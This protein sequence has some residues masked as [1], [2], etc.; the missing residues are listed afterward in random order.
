MNDP[1]LARLTA[2]KTTPTPKL[3]EQWR[4]LFDKVALT[5]YP[6]F[7]QAY[8]LQ[9]TDTCIATQLYIREMATAID[10]RRVCVGQ[11]AANTQGGIA[12]DDELPRAVAWRPD[13]RSCRMRSRRSVCGKLAY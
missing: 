6:S 7:T 1:V 4:L 2:L 9:M 11:E 3:R 8:S 5:W 12:A 13:G 10:L